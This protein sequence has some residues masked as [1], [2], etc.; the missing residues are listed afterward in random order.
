MSEK[1]EEK[2]VELPNKWWRGEYNKTRINGRNVALMRVGLPYYYREREFGKGIDVDNPVLLSEGVVRH[3]RWAEYGMGES[4]KHLTV[5]I[6]YEEL[7]KYYYAEPLIYQ[8]I[9]L[10]ADY[11]LS[12]GFRLSDVS[13]EETK[14][15][16]YIR[17]WCDFVNIEDIIHRMV[18][19]WLIFGTIY[20]EFDIKNNMVQRLVFLHPSTM[21][22]NRDDYGR[23]KSI[24]QTSTSL[25][26]GRE[27]IEWKGNK[28]KNILYLPWNE[29]G[30][31]PY[32]TGLIEPL[33]SLLKIKRS[34][35]QDIAILI[36]RYGTPMRHFKVGTDKFPAKA[37]AVDEVKSALEDYERGQDLIT[38][39]N[40]S[41]ETIESKM[42]IDVRRLY[43]VIFD[44]IIVGIGVPKSFLGLGETS[45]RAVAQ[46][47]LIGFDRRIARIQQR[48]KQILEELIFP[49]VLEVAGFKREERIVVNWNPLGMLSEIDFANA[50]KAL[51]DS[52][53]I[54]KEEAREQWFSRVK[55]ISEK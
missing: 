29:I 32:G 1:T 34:I 14:Q 7:E 3:T 55:L 18:R 26:A 30:I 50:L 48:I 49:R 43:E 31:G 28:L 6:D 52:G 33:L 23:I 2:S 37:S 44:N 27:R 46:I 21:G 9:N 19:E 45:N 41:V 40:V 36:K 13:G 39:H 53:I 5:S 24:V 22:V 12:P 10:I 17:K 54:S 11:V 4:H 25:T 8:G 15:L 42:Q 20:L 47:Q 35:E 38:R 16:E 51:V